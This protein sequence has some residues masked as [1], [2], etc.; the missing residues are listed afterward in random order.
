MKVKE[1]IQQVEK[2]SGRAPEKYMMSL[3]NDALEEIGITKQHKRD[4]VKI[5]LVKDQRWYPLDDSII[6]IVRVEILDTD[7]RYAMIPRLTDYH[8]LLREDEY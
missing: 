1:V 8:K 2:V 3:I 6:D 5:D 7:D 4:E